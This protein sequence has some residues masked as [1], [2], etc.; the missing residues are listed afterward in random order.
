MKLQFKPLMLGAVIAVSA[1]LSGCGGDDAL[2]EK[3]DVFNDVG[4]WCKNPDI[5]QIASP[6]FYPLSD[7][8]QTAYNTARDAAQVE[9]GDDWDEDVWK[10]SFD[11][12]TIFDLTLEEK[13]RQAIAKAEARAFKIEQGQDVVYGDGFDEWFDD[14][15]E[16]IP[17]TDYLGASTRLVK[18][19]NATTPAMDGEEICYTPP[20]SCPNYMEVD[21]TGTYSCVVPALNPIDGAPAPV[22]I[23]QAGEAVAYFRHESHVEGEETANMEYYKNV[24]VHTWNND[25]C[26]AYQETS[27]ANWGSNSPDAQANNGYDDNYGYYWVLKLVDNPDS[28]GNIIYNDTKTGK[29]ISQTDL[30]MPLASSSN[31]AFGNVDK[32]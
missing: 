15:F 4:L 13:E 28:C 1:T 14:W 19:V 11:F 6:D 17:Y 31:I 2:P 23:A 24:V 5:V 12:Y 16:A 27:L 32:N 29:Q 20:V 18:S 25:S 30:V 9:A 21:I 7:D 10:A 26:T 22:Y 3:V 8:E